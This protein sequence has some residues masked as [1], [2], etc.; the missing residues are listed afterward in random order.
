MFCGGKL[1]GE[2]QRFRPAGGN[3]HICLL[4]AIKPGKR[5]IAG[6]F[7]GKKCIAF[8]PSRHG[9]W[10]APV[11]RVNGASGSARVHPKLNHEINET[12]SNGRL[13]PRPASTQAIHKAGRASTCTER[14]SSRKHK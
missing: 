12:S 6:G 5:G 4:L 14:A 9:D 2:L 7:D 13:E 11:Q 3:Q 1:I 10:P 8:C